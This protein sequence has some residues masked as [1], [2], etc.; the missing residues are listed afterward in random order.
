MAIQASTGGT[1]DVTSGQ[2]DREVQRSLVTQNLMASIDL[3]R[4]KSHLEEVGIMRVDFFE[5][6]DSIHRVLQGM[7][8]KVTVT[9]FILEGAEHFSVK[10]VLIPE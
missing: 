9:G 10:I 6:C 5:L 2:L 4:I 7:N 1:I 3:K 8:L